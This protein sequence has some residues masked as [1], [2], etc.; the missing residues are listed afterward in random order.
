M[1]YEEDQEGS[2]EDMD[3]EVYMTQGHEGQ[4]HD[5]TEEGDISDEEDDD[6]YE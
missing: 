4:R 1:D 2:G 3:E 5:L 6:G